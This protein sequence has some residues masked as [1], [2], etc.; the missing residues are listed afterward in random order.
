MMQKWGL[1]TAVLACALLFAGCHVNDTGGAIP[2]PSPSSSPTAAPATCQTPAPI[3][4]SNYVLVAMG[5]AVTASTDPTYGTI[6]G[7]AMWPNQGSGTLPVT[8][9]TIQLHAGDQLQ[10][11]NVDV[12]PL[13]QIVQSAVS[14]PN[15]SA[16]PTVPYT[17]PAN[18]QNPIGTQVSRTVL[19]STGDIAPANSNAFATSGY[20]YSQA[21]AVPATGTYYFGDRL[22]YNL[23]GN[24]DVLVVSP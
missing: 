12:D 18:V 19:W 3:T 10:F 16:F 7:Y 11:I 13:G 23:S 6:N 5:S 2:T 14:F 24:R 15:V 20:C 4:G 1:A 22:Y 17:F 9:A 8:A 21:F